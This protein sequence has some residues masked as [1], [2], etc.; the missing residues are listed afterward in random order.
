MRQGPGDDCVLV[1]LRNWTV[2]Q[3]PPARKEARDG[4]ATTVQCGVQAEVA[5]RLSVDLDWLKR[6][7]GARPGEARVAVM[8]DNA[9]ILAGISD[10]RQSR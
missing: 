2:E 4:K 6:R 10:S 9:R 8:T 7:P 5:D 1:L 3:T